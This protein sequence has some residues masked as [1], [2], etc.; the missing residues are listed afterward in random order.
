MIRPFFNKSTQEIAGIAKQHLGDKDVLDQVLYELSFR[1]SAG[2]VQLRNQLKQVGQS[3]NATNARDGLRVRH[4]DVSGGLDPSTPADALWTA[5]GTRLRQPSTSLAKSTIIGNDSKA[6]T[7]P[8]REHIDFAKVPLAEPDGAV[9][10][11]LAHLPVHAAVSNVSAASRLERAGYSTIGSLQGVCSAHL[12]SVD[13][14]GART[15]DEVLRVMRSIQQGQFDPTLSAARTVDEELWILIQRTGI[16]DVD[17][18]VE[19]LELYHGLTGDRCWTLEEIGESLGL[20]RERIRQLKAQTEDGATEVLQ[21]FGSR[22]LLTSRIAV[23]Q[24]GGLAS[25]GEIALILADSI[26]AGAYNVARF[27]EWLLPRSRDPLLSEVGPGLFVGAPLGVARFQ[28]GV[29]LISSRLSATQCASE[30]ELATL[31]EPFWPSVAPELI[32]HHAGTIASAVGERIMDGYYAA[33]S[34]SRADWAEFVIQSEGR[35]LHFTA[36][37]ERVNRLAQA[38]YNEVGFNGVL[39]TDSRFVRV[40]AGDFALSEWGAEPYNRFDEVIERYL[41]G[42]DY[43]VHEHQMV[44]ELLQTY[45]V[46]PSTVSAMLRMHAGRFKHFGGRYWGL[47]SRMYPTDSVLESAIIT[48]LSRGEPETAEYIHNGICRAWI[49]TGQSLPSLEEVVRTLFLSEHVSRHGT[50]PPQRFRC[51]QPAMSEQAASTTGALIPPQRSRS[52]G[53]TPKS[54]DDLLEAIC[55]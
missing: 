29:T 34:W 39:N 48:A 54:I 49:G 20:T 53:H 3:L 47:T 11:R 10:P 19:I 37:A 22:V 46:A 12:L 8:P 21:W 24:L 36:V 40:G 31:I 16:S 4:C 9:P 15:A 27:V 25:S 41:K 33:N 51:I 13:G 28:E 35:P 26:G 18:A 42:H 38:E 43:A 52:A 50:L 32:S 45:T 14:L 7:S 30:E 17:R 5:A 23:A 55:W 1:K 6:I 2:A 44:T